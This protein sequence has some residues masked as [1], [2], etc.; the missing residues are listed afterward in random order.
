MSE[1]VTTSTALD[2]LRADRNDLVAIARGLT[3]AQWASP[4]GCEGW[5]IQDL[6]SHMA[7]LFWD[8]VDGSVAPDT[9]RLEF[10]EAASAKV[11]ARR[12]MT[13]PEVLADYEAVSTRA[14]EAL[15]AV[16]TLDMDI[17]FSDFESYHASLVPLAFCFDH[18]THVRAD[19]F[20]PRG[21]LTGQPPPSDEL[22]LGPA[23]G[24]IEAVVAKQ[25][26]AVLSSLTGQIELVVTGTGARTIHVGEGETVAT[27]ESDG[28][29]FVRWITGRAAWEEVGVKAEGPTAA[30]E[31]AA[32]I[33]VY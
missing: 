18:Y 27:I 33:K 25:N 10:E 5:T 8:V 23:L 14:L 15:P 22:R 29:S 20:A 32:S 7:S 26:A 9:S 16:A 1:R 31:T 19:L 21:S 2:A 11:R 4:S 17:P 28:P 12:M 24:W 3:S 30:I 13:A 6:M